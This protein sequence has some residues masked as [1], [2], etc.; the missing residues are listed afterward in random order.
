MA[1][2]GPLRTSSRRVGSTSGSA[3]EKVLKE[4]RKT[5]KKPE[6][7][8][9]VQS[10]NKKK[11][12]PREFQKNKEG[13]SPSEALKDADN[14]ENASKCPNKSQRDRS[15]N[16]GCTKVDN[17][18]ANSKKV[19]KS[20][21][22]VDMERKKGDK[23]SKVKSMSET[24]HSKAKRKADG[25][26]NRSVSSATP[27][28]KAAVT[29]KKEGE[30]DCDF[31]K[32]E[33]LIFEGQSA[34]GVSSV[35][36]DKH[37]VSEKGKGKLKKDLSRTPK[38]NGIK[39]EKNHKKHKSSSQKGKKRKE[40]VDASD[41]DASDWEEVEDTAEINELEAL[42]DDSQNT[43]ITTQ[44]SVKIELDAPDVVWGM[45]RRKKRRT[46]EEMVS[47]HIESI[48]FLELKGVLLLSLNDLISSC[49]KFNVYRVS[50]GDFSLDLFTYILEWSLQKNIISYYNRK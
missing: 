15:E 33:G 14:K 50:K 37:K 9:K 41:S 16:R 22:N 12:K 23:L 5:E 40:K 24:G 7:G 25:K 38:D 21:A 39:S 28:R 3:K 47:H 20:N 46:E 48:K 17:S 42:L 27:K 36:S 45:K 10:S 13:L 19:T 18:S 44:E 29:P 34:T 11:P 32:I 4:K 1:A 35:A 6:N 49:K 26:H 30:E 2:D 31:S 8:D 43:H